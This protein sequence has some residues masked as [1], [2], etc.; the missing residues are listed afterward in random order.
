MLVAKVRPPRI[1]AFRIST[2]RAAPAT[3]RFGSRGR[4]RRDRGDGRSTSTPICCASARSARAKRREAG[5]ARASSRAM[6]RRC[7]S[8][9][10]SFDA[11]TIAFGI[12]NVPR[13]ERGAGR[14][15]SRSQARRAFS[16]PGILARST[17]RC[18]TA[19]YD[20]YSY[21]AIPALG[22]VVT[23]DGAPYRYLV[24][25]IRKFPDARALRRHDR[26]GRLRARRL[27]RALPAASSPSIPAGSSETCRSL[28]PIGHASR[29]PRAGF[30]L[31]REGAF[32]GIDP[33]RCRRSRAL[34]LALANLP[35]AARREGLAGLSAAIDR[36]GPSYVKL[37]QF[38]ATRPDIVGPQVVARTRDAAGPD[39]AAVRA[40]AAVAAIEAA[41]G[42]ASTRSSSTSASPSPRPRSPRCIARGSAT[43]RRA[44]RRGQSLAAR[45]RAAVRARSLRHVFR[46]ALRRALSR[47]DCGGCGRSQVVETLA[48]IGA[49]GDGFSPR[50]RGGLRIR[51][52]PR[53]TIRTFARRRSTGTAPR[54]KCSRM[55]WIDGAPLSDPDRA[56]PRLG[57]DPPKLGRTL[58]QSFLRHALRDGFFHADM[59]QGNFF[60][61]AE[62]RIVAVDF[63]IMGRLGR[64]ERRF[65]AEILYG[66]ITARLPAG[67]RGPFRGG[68]CAAR[69]TGSR[70]SRRRS[71]PSASRSIRAPPS[72][73]RWRNC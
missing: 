58:I 39:G 49:H 61:D 65:L 4:R 55:E 42:Q 53:R 64:K 51:R 10:R 52:K 33:P 21:A 8:P 27:R 13:I 12:R 66:F 24:E 28:A 37:G 1:G 63:G 29:L 45:R 17:C 7:R 18:S 56:S 9:T 6:P 11:Y 20:A 46:G 73:S 15:L 44:R 40:S 30:V 43:P 35:G 23:G 41:F 19:L 70:I 36:L 62:G 34:P 48:R 68:L 3:S 59:H 2:S 5:R 50:G 47:R 25:S 57:F 72:R 14:G 60:V 16:L 22:K 54:A 67:R 69:S 32:V 38:L 31:A 71:A 26:R